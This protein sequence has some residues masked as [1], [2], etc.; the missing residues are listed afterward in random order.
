M[1]D[2][3]LAALQT[4][5]NGATPREL[6][7]DLQLSPTSPLSETLHQLKREGQIIRAESFDENG[8]RVV[9]YY[10]PE[11]APTDPAQR[12]QATRG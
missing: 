4:K 7:Y 5:Q 9:R 11:F 6:M 10:A 2:R 1:R 12:G 3:V 8:T